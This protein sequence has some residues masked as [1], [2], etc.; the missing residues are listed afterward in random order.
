MRTV[1]A[2]GINQGSIA[3]PETVCAATAGSPSVLICSAPSMFLPATAT[4]MPSARRRFPVSARQG[5][6]TCRPPYSMR[7]TPLSGEDGLFP[8]M[9]KDS[10]IAKVPSSAAASLWH[11]ESKVP[12]AP[13]PHNPISQTPMTPRMICPLGNAAALMQSDAANNTNN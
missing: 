4:G 7:I 10:I 12:A 9:P 2:S 3:L 13:L 11:S 8:T 5:R 6:Q 1:H